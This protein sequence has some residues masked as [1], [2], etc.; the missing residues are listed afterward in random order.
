MPQDQV[1]ITI[2][3]DNQAGPGLAVEHG[4]SLWIET[5]HRR[6]LFDTGQ[7]QAL[8]PNTR[9]LG[10]DPAAADTLVLSHGH[11]DHTGGIARVLE[12]NPACRVYGHPG[13][14][15]PRWAVRDG[16]TRAIGIPAPSLAAVEGLAPARRTWVSAPLPLG[17]RMGLTGPIARCTDFEDPGGPFFLDP[18]GRH[19][20]PISDD[21]ALWIDTRHGVVVCVGCCH[22]GLVNTLAQVRRINGQKPIHALIGGFHLVAAG[23]L[24]LDR[25]IATL[26]GL[27]PA[28]VVPCHCTGEPAMAALQ[29]AM[30]E[31][32]RFGAAGTV[33]RF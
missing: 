30:P 11:Y 31:Q 10:V 14:V 18:A 9:A 32:V 2:L 29:A 19:P 5:R 7:G 24:R 21:L 15:A 12:I 6:I 1:Q 3:V 33:Y 26:R 22:A 27:Q 28:L 4:F 8:W 20:D 25:T 13:I 23:R 17:P 16:E